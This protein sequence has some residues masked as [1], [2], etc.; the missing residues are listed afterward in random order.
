MGF[1]PIGVMANPFDTTNDELEPGGD[2]ATPTA[3]TD[4]VVNYADVMLSTSD[5]GNTDC[6]IQ[7]KDSSG[8]SLGAA[9]AGAGIN[10]ALIY[11]LPVGYQ[12]NWGA[13][14]GVAPTVIAS[15]I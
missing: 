5:S 8:N 6:S 2:A 10:T 14:T 1:N 11:F 7:M 9:L 4:Y 3:S 12:I 13:F 15:F